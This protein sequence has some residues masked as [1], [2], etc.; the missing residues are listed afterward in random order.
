MI[1]ADAFN[2]PLKNKSVDLIITSPPFFYNL[3]AMVKGR[4]PKYTSKIF[5]LERSEVEYREKTEAVIKEMHRVC[6]GSIWVHTSR[7]DLWWD[8]D[9]MMLEPWHYPESDVFTFW[10]GWRANWKNFTGW[11]EEPAYK[12]GHWGV[13]PDKLV[14]EIIKNHG[15]WNKDCVVLD[16]F[17]GTG[18]VGRVANE[19]GYTGINMDLNGS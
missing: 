10:V 9:V 19:A 17:A 11:K 4:N 1:I 12:D 8:K 16:P 15:G 14:W 7:P 5:G 13:F 18:V 3:S 2:M 6:K